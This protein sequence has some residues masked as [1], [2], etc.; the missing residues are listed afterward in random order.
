MF[1][2]AEAE[3]GGCVFV[4]DAGSIEISLSEHDG[5]GLGVMETEA[6]ALHGFADK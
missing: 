2:L 1:S 4:G 3:S 6:L 5:N